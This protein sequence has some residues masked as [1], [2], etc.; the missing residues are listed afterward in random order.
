MENESVIG[1]AWFDENDWEEWKKISDDK[2]EEKYED[3][4]IEAALAKLKYEDEGFV[5]KEVKITPG[6]F[7][8]WCKRNN[9]KLNSSSR[10]EYVS[11]LLL[12]SHS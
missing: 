1:I 9:K 4:L 5:I 12:K 2:I 8:K 7:K 6:R 11:E 10:S 3:W